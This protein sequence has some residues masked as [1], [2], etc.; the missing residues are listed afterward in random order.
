VREGKERRV[1]NPP[2]PHL[3]RNPVGIQQIRLR[4]DLLVL[5][6]RR[7]FVPSLIMDS[8]TSVED[9]HQ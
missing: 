6:W 8:W 3:F 9:P 4:I 5:S 2:S 7:R 1:P